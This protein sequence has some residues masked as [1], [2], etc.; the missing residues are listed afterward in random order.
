MSR[1][2]VVTLTSTAGYAG[3]RDPNFQM[4]VFVSVIGRW[5]VERD[6]IVGLRIGQAFPQEDG[7][8]VVEVERETPALGGQHLERQIRGLDLARFRNTLEELL[9]V[10]GAQHAL[11]GTKRIDAVEGDASL[12]QLGR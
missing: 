6:L 1:L 4:M 5:R 8:V 7:D 9:I 2:R 10:V 12:L 11:A 3:F